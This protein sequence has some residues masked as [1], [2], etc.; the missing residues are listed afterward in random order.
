MIKFYK[1]SLCNFIINL[2]RSPYVKILLSV[3]KVTKTSFK[4]VRNK[5]QNESMKMI[6]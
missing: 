2:Y 4:K 3:G 6:V 5:L 1:L